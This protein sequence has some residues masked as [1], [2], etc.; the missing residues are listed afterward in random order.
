M[1]LQQL[2]EHF[3]DNF[4]REHDCD[5]RPFFLNDEHKVTGMFGVAHITS[6]FTPL[7]TVYDTVLIEGGYAAQA[8]VSTDKMPPIKT[9]KINRLLEKTLNKPAHV[10]SIV[11]FDRLSRTV[12][13]L[14]YLELAGKDNFLIT[15]VDPRH[16]LSIPYNHGVYFE[17]IIRYTGLKTENVVISMTLTG[18]HQEHYPQL[19]QG[20]KNY[21]ERGYKI[22]LNIGHLISAD[23]TISFINQLYPD[24]VIVTAPNDSYNSLNLNSSLMTALH[25]LKELTSLSAAKTIFKDVTNA[26]QALCAVHIGFDLVQ[27]DYYETA[28]EFYTNMAKYKR[29]IVDLNYTN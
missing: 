25:H 14:N 26:E 4:E 13:L 1:S 29:N 16:I 6:Q 20:L 12:N 24:F 10:R 15:E 28:P 22:A 19:L 21:R 3:N 27:G 8:I 2:V 9:A 23:K 18:V 7:H 5:F 17:E 11:T